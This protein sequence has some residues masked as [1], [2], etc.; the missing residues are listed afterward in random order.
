MGSIPDFVVQVPDR[1]AT[2]GRTGPA[3]LVRTLII[4]PRCPQCG[5]PRGEPYLHS[6]Y[7]DGDWYVVSR[8]DNPCGHRDLYEEVL[9]EGNAYKREERLAK[10][11]L[12]LLDALVG[13]SQKEKLHRI[14]EVFNAGE[15]LA[16]AVLGMEE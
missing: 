9:I 14:L 4:S 11:F 12:D 13:S 15:A 1:A 8:W 6:F 10:E 16:K 5:E 7:E 2:W 3:V